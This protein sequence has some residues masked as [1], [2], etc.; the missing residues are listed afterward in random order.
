MKYFISISFITLSLFYGTQSF[1]QNNANRYFAFPQPKSYNGSFN[2][3]SENQTI[4][5]SVI[6]TIPHNTALLHS[7]SNIEHSVTFYEIKND[8]SLEFLGAGISAK[9]RTYQ[10]IYDDIQFQTIPFPLGDEKRNPSDTVQAYLGIGVRMTATIST[11]KKGLDLSDP[12]VLSA[13]RENVKGSIEIQIIGITS[14][15]IS[16][17]VPTTTD[18][19]TSSISSAIQSIS[20]IRSHLYDPETIISPQLIGREYTDDE[21]YDLTYVE[22]KSKRP[23][24]S[25]AVF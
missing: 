14:S 1:C 22:E 3:L 25:R 24:R 6:D 9:N 2:Y 20:I 23:L 16:G 4:I 12:L 7:L 17:L 18:L 5:N 21:L 19:S 15:K 13:N 10:V 11:K 8:G